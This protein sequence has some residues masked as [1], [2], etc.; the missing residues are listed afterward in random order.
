MRFL[1]TLLLFVAGVVLGFMIK[2]RLAP[3]A[4]PVQTP[5]RPAQAESTAPYV[6][7]PADDG[8]AESEQAKPA[9]AAE[10]PRDAG[11][12]E[13]DSL[14][15]TPVIEPS[16][17]GGSASIASPDD[18][19]SSPGA[20]EGK[21]LVLQLQMIT[22][23][24]TGSGWRLNLVHTGPGKKVDYLY[25]DDSGELGDKPDLR[26]GY[27]YRVRFLCSAGDPASGNKLLAIEP[28]GGKADW[29]TGLSAVE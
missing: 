10:E 22:A 28:T 18:F 11:E 15:E 25:V 14:D 7:D 16:A 3:A 8:L 23:K 2:E 20:Y 17:P 26:I 5:Y 9:Q 21:E 12:N 29:A 4:A 19:F 13:K 27:S 24:K 6:P 1:N